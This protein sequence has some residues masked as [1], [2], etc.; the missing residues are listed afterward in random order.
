MYKIIAS[1]LF[2]HKKC[3]LPGIGTL[4]IVSR[5]A[6]TDFLNTRI[7][8]PSQSIEFISSGKENV[9][10]TE[11]LAISQFIR[12]KL[13]EERILLLNGIG[14]FTQFDEGK[15]DFFPISIDPVF[16]PDAEAV[17]VIRQEELHEIAEAEQPIVNTELPEYFNEKISLIDL[18]WFRA[19][20]LAVIGFLIMLIYFY[21]RGINLFGNIGS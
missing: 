17:R 11:F 6:E 5:S 19:I 7:Q 3:T 1:S 13:A 14:T 12:K 2:L 10:S 18:W 21:Q 4:I 8:S 20:V 9:F 15:Y 16:I